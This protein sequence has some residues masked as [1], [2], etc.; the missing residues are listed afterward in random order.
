MNA[1]TD[2]FPQEETQE[3]AEMDLFELFKQAVGGKDESTNS[4][5]AG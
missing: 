4:N 1:Q 5:D 2:L 3:E